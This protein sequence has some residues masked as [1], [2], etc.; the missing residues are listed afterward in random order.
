MRTKHFTTNFTTNSAKNRVRFVRLWLLLSILYIYVPLA[1]CGGGSGP[2]R[3]PV[4]T[5]PPNPSQQRTWFPL[6]GDIDPQPIRRTPRFNI[7][8]QSNDFDRVRPKAINKTTTYLNKSGASHLIDQFSQ[9]ANEVGKIP[10]WID[11]AYEKNVLQYKNCGGKFLSF[12]NSHNPQTIKVE[13]IAIPQFVTYHQVWA[14]GLVLPDQVNIRCVIVAIN[15]L[16]TNPKTSDLRQFK[17]YIRWEIGNI[18]AMRYGHKA[19]KISKEWGDKIPCQQTK[20]INS[21]S[22]ISHISSISSISKSKP[23]EIKY[24]TYKSQDREC[25]Q[26]GLKRQETFIS[27]PVTKT[28]EKT[29]K[30]GD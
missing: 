16:Q 30:K 9:M 27:I 13:V 12:I 21:K 23:K 25:S 20:D 15:G 4:V 22:S 3:P 19:T 7:Q 17:D 29:K 6:L 24:V 5:N 26:I 11:E 28:T 1:G 14:G 8:Y 2:N 18:L 10:L